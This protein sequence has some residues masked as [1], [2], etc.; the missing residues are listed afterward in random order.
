M[1]NPNLASVALTRDGHALLNECLRIGPTGISPLNIGRANFAAITYSTNFCELVADLLFLYKKHSIANP[2]AR[3]SEHFRRLKIDSCRGADMT[4]VRVEYLVN[5]NVVKLD[6][7]SVYRVLNRLTRSE[8]PICGHWKVGL[9]QHMQVAHPRAI[10]PPLEQEMVA[11]P[12]SCGLLLPSIWL[13]RLAAGCMN[14]S[15]N[16]VSNSSQTH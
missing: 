14:S 16:K 9:E 7:V 13:W 4:Y 3:L 12:W 1:N 11:Q 5:V 10:V 15:W 8:C 2:I 6:K